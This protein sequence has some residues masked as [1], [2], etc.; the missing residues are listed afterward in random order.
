LISPLQT[1]LGASNLP[2]HSTWRELGSLFEEMHTLSNQ[3][4][5]FPLK[6]SKSLKF[7]LR[8]G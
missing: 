1:V 2:P 7:N 8:F 4:M 5:R 3:Q 6:G